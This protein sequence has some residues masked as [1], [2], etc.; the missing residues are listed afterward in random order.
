MGDSGGP[1]VDVTDPENK[2]LVGIVS[3]GI[4]VIAWN[5]STSNIKKL[6]KI[7]FSFFQIFQ[8]GR[9]K[10][11]QMFCCIFPLSFVYWHNFIANLGYPDVFTRVHYHL[12]WIKE[13]I[14]EQSQELLN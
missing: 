11:I 1:L 2:T 6:I 8:C 5:Y 7:L 14:E 10:K 9:G 13:R 4:P 12:E 3:W